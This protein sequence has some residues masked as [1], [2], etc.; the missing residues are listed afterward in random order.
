M[1]PEPERTTTPQQQERKT[2]ELKDLPA[3]DER[4]DVAN[5]VKGGVV[6]PCGRPR[7]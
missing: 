6:G 2:T 3:K 7:Q 1:S 4:Q 5:T